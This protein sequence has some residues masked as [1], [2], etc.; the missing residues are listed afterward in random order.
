VRSWHYALLAAGALL[1]APPGQGPYDIA[2]RASSRVPGAEGH[3]RIFFA[4]S[5]F[6]VAVTEDGRARYDV[7]ITAASLP[8]PSSLGSYAAYV[9][10]EV[11]TDLSA[12]HRLGVITN[13][14][15]TVG[16]TSLNKFLLVIT[17]ERDSTGTTH[18]GPVVL[19]GHSPSGWLQSFITHPLFR[20]IAQ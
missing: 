6:G 12:W 20:G 10:W 16:E 9:A 19:N 8:D 2:L 1:A 15:T 3:A 7:R 4:E 13:G 14:E 18:A 5:P 17:A 11:A